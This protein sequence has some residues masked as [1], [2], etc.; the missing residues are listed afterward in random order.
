MR[1]TILTVISTTLQG[2]ADSDIILNNNNPQH[3]I[4]HKSPSFLRDLMCKKELIIDP[5][6]SRFPR[7]DPLHVSSSSRTL[8]FYGLLSHKN[9]W[10]STWQY[11]VFSWFTVFF[12]MFSGLCIKKNYP[13]FKY[14]WKSTSI[15]CDVVLSKMVQYDNTFVVN[16]YLID[17]LRDSAYVRKSVF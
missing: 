7:M 10:F 11:D 14:I 1:S 12:F 5:L 13:F 9:V 17:I 6:Q 2:S 8:M 16:N 3:F 4:Q 15:F